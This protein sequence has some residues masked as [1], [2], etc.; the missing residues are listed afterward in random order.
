MTTSTSATNETSKDTSKDTS[1]DTSNDTISQE[2]LALLIRRHQRREDRQRPGQ[3]AARRTYHQELRRRFPVTVGPPQPPAHNIAWLNAN[4]RRA[5]RRRH[6][7]TSKWHPDLP[8]LSH[9]WWPRLLPGDYAEIES[10][11]WLWLRSLELV[12]LNPKLGHHLVQALSLLQG[13]DPGQST[14]PSLTELNCTRETLAGYDVGSPHLLR[15]L[16]ISISALCGEHLC[17]NPD[18]LAAY[19]QSKEHQF[20]PP[21]PVYPARQDHHCVISNANDPAARTLNLQIETTKLVVQ[22]SALRTGRTADPATI[23]RRLDSG[24]GLFRT[25]LHGWAEAPG[26]TEEQRKNQGG[27]EPELQAIYRCTIEDA[28]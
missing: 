5:L 10:G 13:T 9:R 6:Q 14:L 21:Y 22:K 11:C 17:V 24:S 12:T 20:D 23:G 26:R 4:H 3:A 15:M 2:R 16:G 28:V 18:H 1:N 19:L 27:P 25:T 8:R 7:L